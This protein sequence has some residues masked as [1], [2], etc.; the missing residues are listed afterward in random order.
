MKAK[1][2]ADQTLPPAGTPKSAPRFVWLL[3]LAT[4]ICSPLPRAAHANTFQASAPSGPAAASNNA[5]S[6]EVPTLEQYHWQLFEAKDK[7]GKHIDALFV[8]PDK[9]LQLDFTVSNIYV[10]NTCNRMSGS[11]T[12]KRDQLQINPLASTLMACIDP[13]MSALDAAIGQRLQGQLAFAIKAGEASPQLRLVTRAG[14]TLSFAGHAT[15][16]T[17]YGGPGETVFLEVAAQ[18]VPCKPADATH[19]SCLQVRERHYDEHGLQVGQ[20]GAWQ[21]MA[22]GI[23][24]YTHEPG[25]RNV[26]RVKRYRIAN[27]PAGSPPYAFVLDLIVESEKV[28]P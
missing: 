9:P 5:A 13:S 7:A 27:A 4:A 18:T 16:E 1:D 11:F 22:E 2:I 21:P 19:A 25:I 26:L 3:L 20:P 23:E 10:S 24:G 6:T 15:A 14:D 8:R 17:R 12:V 28:N